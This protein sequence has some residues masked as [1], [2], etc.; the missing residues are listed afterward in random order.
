MGV[1]DSSDDDAPPPPPPMATVAAAA[2]SPSNLP[3]PS[4]TAAAADAGAGVQGLKKRKKRKTRGELKKERLAALQKKK[5]AKSLLLRKRVA[6]E[7][8][9][10]QERDIN[11]G[12]EHAG[13]RVRPASMAHRRATSALLSDPA[14]SS[15]LAS[16]HADAAA[17]AEHHGLQSEDSFEGSSVGAMRETLETMDSTE[18]QQLRGIFAAHDED[19]DGL[20]TNSELQESLRALGFIP[21]D[22]LMRKYYLERAKR[23]PDTM[24]HHSMAKSRTAKRRSMAS[25]R[26]D[27]ASFMAAS[28][29]L[30][31]AESA[32][33][34]ILPLFEEIDAAGTGELTITDLKRLL[35]QVASPTRLSAQELDELFDAAPLLQGTLHDKLASVEY[36]DLVESLLFV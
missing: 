9:L 25:F 34:E 29:H 36:E 15:T 20:L 30:D 24:P 10:Q 31:T 23:D 22:E 28:L 13:T 1:E 14:M 7:K 32:Y 17:E 18:L 35:N 19:K 12:E 21:N 6:Q 8:Q 11:N 33:D 3:P 4:P 27:L 26:M 5:S 16:L 2:E